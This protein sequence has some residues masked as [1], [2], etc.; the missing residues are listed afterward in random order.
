[1]VNPNLPSAVPSGLPLPSPEQA[2]LP[3]I[4]AYGA[5]RLAV[6]NGT[7]DALGALAAPILPVAIAAGTI[8]VMAYGIKKMFQ[9]ILGK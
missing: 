2:A 9:P 3:N 7:R 8:G 5:E 1:M 4:E 6:I